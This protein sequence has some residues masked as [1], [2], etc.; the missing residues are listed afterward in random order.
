MDFGCQSF[1]RSIL[2]NELDDDPVDC[3]LSRD[4]HH[5]IDL[6]RVIL[7]V[8]VELVDDNIRISIDDVSCEESVFEW[9]DF[10]VTS[11]CE[12]EGLTV[13]PQLL[14]R[15]QIFIHDEVRVLSVE[16][17]W[18]IFPRVDWIWIF[19]QRHVIQSVTDLFDIRSL[20]IV[21]GLWWF[22]TLTRFA[23][24][25]CF[26]GSTGVSHLTQMYVFIQI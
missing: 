14:S 21:L 2:E 8:L 19:Q 5:E 9:E 3:E 6:K 18:V 10:P 24:S 1:D 17:D 25:R 20:N 15:V 11:H 4:R 26:Q 12:L 13:W 22:Y 7:I 16:L 23:V